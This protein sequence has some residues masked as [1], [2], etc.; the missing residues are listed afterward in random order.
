[1]TDP[2]LQDFSAS[3]PAHLVQQACLRDGTK[4]TIR[5]IR[6]EDDDIVRAFLRGVSRESRWN[7]L[8]SARRLTP[9]EIRHLTRIDY[10]HEMA[11]IA[12]TSVDGKEREIGVARYVVDDDMAGAEFALLIT[13]VWQRR[14]VGTLLMKTLLRH[15]RSAGLARL[16]GITHSD[17]TAMIDLACKLGFETMAVPAD[18]TL[19]EVV[20]VLTPSDLM[21]FP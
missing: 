9:Q 17:N 12:V 6:P 14:G 21:F 15:A 4:I 10:E 16:H 7:R 18:A 8:L 13:D 1:M 2:G 20:K 3:Y 19:Q 11:F 5:P